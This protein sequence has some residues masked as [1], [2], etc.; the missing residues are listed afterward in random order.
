MSFRSDFFDEIRS[1]NPALQMSA[2]ESVF[3]NTV[4]RGLSAHHQDLELIREEMASTFSAAAERYAESSDAAAQIIAD[5]IGYQAEQTRKSNRQNASRIMATIEQASVFLGAQL[6]EVRWAVERNS[7]L[8]QQILDTLWNTHWTDSRQHFEEGVQCYEQGEREFARERFT[9]ATEACRTNAF[10]Y[11]YLGFLAVHDNDQA[12]S[13]RFFDLALK[14]A[15]SDKHRAW[16]YYHLA[17]VWHAAGD[18]TKSLEHIRRA[19]ALSPDELSY[20]FELVRALVR[21]G[22]SNDAIEELRKLIRRDLRYW[23]AA[24]IDRSLDQVR[25]QITDLLTAMRQE[26]E[27][28]ANSVFKDFLETITI[29]QSYS[30]GVSVDDSYVNELKASMGIL[31]K[32][33]TISSFREVVLRVRKGHP[34]FLENAISTLKSRLSKTCQN[35]SELE[36]TLRDRIE[37]RES[38]LKKLREEQARIAPSLAYRLE[39]IDRDKE[40]QSGKGAALG[41][42]GCLAVPGALIWAGILF[43]FFVY[44]KSTGLPDTLGKLVLFSPLILPLVLLVLARSITFGQKKKAARSEARTQEVEIQSRT[45]NVE[46]EIAA[47]KQAGRDEL[48]RASLEFDK[49]SSLYERQ[50]SILEARL[51]LVNSAVA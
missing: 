16:A 8:T 1:Y 5:E 13:L 49:A 14:F 44:K 15:P 28:V 31:F 10:A 33:G 30:P 17:R 38:E 26:E 11:Q 7:E 41:C 48:Q 35:K 50:I 6:T 9:K 36:S 3:L 39:Q 40:S 20:H 23:T 22:L 19:F 45:E 4:D 51:Y 21:A 12:Q 18:E 25:A 43:E 34:E 42:T 24:A 47:Q 46:M 27:V 32:K 37:A 2:K 29:V